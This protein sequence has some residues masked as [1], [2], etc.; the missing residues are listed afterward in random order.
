MNVCVLVGF[1]WMGG[2]GLVLVVILGFVDLDGVG[3]I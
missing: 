1:V 3:I 2:F